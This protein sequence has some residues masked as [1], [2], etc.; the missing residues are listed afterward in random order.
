MAIN[1]IA[2]SMAFSNGA[3]LWVLPD[4]TVSDWANR[5]DWYL[6]FQIARARQHKAPVIPSGLVEILQETNLAL[7]T[8]L[9]LG[10]AP[11]MLSCQARLPAKQTVILGFDDELKEWCGQIFQIWQSLKQP[12]LRVFLPKRISFSQ[13][14]AAWPKSGSEP[15]AF[16]CDDESAKK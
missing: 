12:S 3:D 14:Q 11:L 2:E 5:V 13:L 4:P 16:V 9:S 10:K 15:V 1:R 8:P 7:P 6:N